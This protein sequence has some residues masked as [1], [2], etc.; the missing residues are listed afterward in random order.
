MGRKKLSDNLKLIFESNSQ[1]S[2]F[3]GYYNYSPLSI[4][5][6]K[7]LCNRANF[8]SIPVKKGMKIEVGYYS[9]EDGHWHHIE[10]SDSWNW[11]QG[12]MLQWIPNSSDEVI[13]NSSHNNRL[14]SV[15]CNLKTKGKRI[16]CMPIYGITPDGR[17]SITLDMERSYWCRAYHYQSVENKEK[18]G[19]LYENDGIFDLNLVNNECKR[20]ISIQDVIKADYDTS[21]E[22]MKHWLEHIMISPSGKRF[23]F[24]HRF[25]SV[26][27]V[28]DYGTRICIA[29]IDGSNLQ[30]IP[31][32]KYFSWSHFAWNGDNSFSI[33][34][35]KQSLFHQVPSIGVLIKREPY[36]IDLLLKRI[37]L[38]VVARLPKKLRKKVLG[39]ATYYQYYT[40]IGNK[41]TLS[42]CFDNTEFVIDGHPSF[43]KD[44]VTM[45]TDTYP[46]SAGM[47]HLYKYDILSKKVIDLASFSLQPLGG[48]ERCDLHP[49]LSFNQQ[50]IFVDSDYD[51]KRKVLGFKFI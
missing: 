45:I 36:R 22:K 27:D 51:G 24:L 38:T 5:N 39:E 16:L 30:V 9:L 7:I 46:D 12:A 35:Y 40:I 31:G 26:E 28:L 29:D 19:R 18:E 14:V 3:F 4:D 42:D 49:K 47:Q 43:M 25:S 13:F 21:F 1:Y 48:N 11:Q 33:F 37:F 20:I 41:F 32:W 23:V 6:K 10:Y 8:G 17:H 44:G 50:F 15:L 2:E 34:T